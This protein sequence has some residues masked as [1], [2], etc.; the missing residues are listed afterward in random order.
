MKIPCFVRACLGTAVIA[1]SP[2]WAQAP[3]PPDLSGAD[4]HWIYDPHSKCWAGDPDPHDGETI[5]WEGKCDGGLVS[6]FGTLTWYRG[7]R[8]DGRDIG[9]FAAGILSGR[10]KIIDGDGTVFEGEFPGRGVLTLPDGRTLEAVTVREEAGWSIEQA[11]PV[12]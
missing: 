9:T 8:I 1:A 11:P 3:K 7:G 2:V 5:A 10:G 4:P 6:G 12:P